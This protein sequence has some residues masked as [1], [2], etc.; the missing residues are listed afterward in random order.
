MLGGWISAA[1]SASRASRPAEPTSATRVG[2][3]NDRSHVTSTAEEDSMA[4]AVGPSR[5]RIDREEI[6]PVRTD[7]KSEPFFHLRMARWVN[8]IQLQGQFNDLP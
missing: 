2:E 4:G 5:S 6:E 3:E 8:F 1:R 7:Q